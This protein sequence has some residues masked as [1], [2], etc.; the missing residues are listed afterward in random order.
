MSIPHTQSPRHQGLSSE[1]RG[2]SQE[3]NHVCASTSL[4]NVQ[5]QGLPTLPKDPNAVDEDVDLGF[6]LSSRI[7]TFRQR[8]RTSS[9]LQRHHDPEQ[10]EQFIVNGRPTYQPKEPITIAQKDPLVRCA[11]RPSLS[12]TDSTTS[13]VQQAADKF[14]GA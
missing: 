12:Q 14:S 9:E 10:K 2:A 4:Q 11:A 13:V 7:A 8:F 3:E 6:R 5:S 1:A